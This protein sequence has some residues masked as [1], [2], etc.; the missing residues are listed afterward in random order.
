MELHVLTIFPQM[1]TSFLQTSLLGRAV[2]RGLVRVRLWNIREWAT[3]RHRSTD[4]VPYG[5]GPGMVMKPEPIVACLEAVAAQEGPARRV[6]LS[7]A[8]PRLDQRR[9]RDL[10]AAGRVALVCGR[11]EGVDERVRKHVDEEL[12]IGD[13]V[14]SGGEI[15]A[16]VV[17][18]A[19]ARLVPGVLGDERSLC[20]ESF[21]AGLLEY[22]QYTRP[23]DFRGEGVPPMLLQGDHARIAAWRRRHALIRTRERRPDLFAQFALSS[24]DA[25]LLRNDE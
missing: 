11:Y 10:C 19:V 4:D 8:G 5:G 13:Y 15:A 6:L 2:S 20:E 1:L 18:D 7:P 22:P 12:S 3:D 23:P 14:L 17:I 9:T 24:E 25:R 21:A 16:M